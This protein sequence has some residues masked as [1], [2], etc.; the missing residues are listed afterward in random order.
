MYR[1]LNIL[2]LTLLHSI[3]D[4]FPP[5]T[6]SQKYSG[7]LLETVCSIAV[8]LPHIQTYLSTCVVFLVSRIFRLPS[9]SVRT[10]HSLALT[11]IFNFNHLPPAY[12]KSLLCSSADLPPWQF[13][14][15]NIFP[16]AP[17]NSPP[18]LVVW[19]EFPTHCPTLECACVYMSGDPVFVFRLFLSRVSWGL[20]Q[21]LSCSG[22]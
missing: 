16:Q 18:L 12:K 19:N 13:L 20:S 4:F 3:T 6:D 14:I 8:F 5:Q 9:M 15:L 22:T 2:G 17:T 7:D 11:H 21:N 1:E 10:L